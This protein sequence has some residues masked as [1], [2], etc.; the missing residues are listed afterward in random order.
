MLSIASAKKVQGG[1][2]RVDMGQGF[3]VRAGIFDG[4]ISV[5]ALQW[6]CVASRKT[7]NPFKRCCKFFQTLY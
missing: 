5:S 6:L 2:F 7:D 3:K 4:V 1:L